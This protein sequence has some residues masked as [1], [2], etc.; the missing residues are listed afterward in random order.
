MS[1]Y[2]IV[3]FWLLFV[4]V[5]YAESLFLYVS[6]DGNDQWSGR[7]ANASEQDGPFATIERA[8]Q[9]VRRL[10]SVDSL[11]G[12]MTVYLRGGVYYLKQEIL[13]TPED[14]GREDAPIRYTNYDDETVFI[15]GGRKLTAWRHV[16]DN[17]WVCDLPEAKGDSWRFQQLFVNGERRYRART[18]N[19]G[20]L[21]V[22]DAMEKPGT[23]FHEDRFKFGFFPGDLLSNWRN[24][25]DI[26]IVLLTFWSDAHCPIKKIDPESLVVTLS[27]PSWRK[28]TDDNSDLGARYFVDNVYEGMD[29]PGEWYLDR[30]K[31]RLYYLAMP[32][33][34]MT[35]AEVIAP[36]LDQLIRFNGD[37]MAQQY[38][39]N[40]AISGLHFA[41]T[42]WRL[43]PGDAGDHQAADS[44]PGAVEMVG[45]RHVKIENC[46]FEHLGTYGMEILD[47]CRDIVIRKNYIH[48]LGGGGVK[49]SGG[50]A[51]SDSLL[52]T[53]HITFSDN[54]LK[55]MGRLYKASVGVLL[56]HASDNII[57]HNLIKDLFYT[58][59]S[60]GWEW[61][62]QA[63]AAY[64]NLIEFNRVENVG[65]GMLS[66]MGG[67]YLLGVSPGTVVRNNLVTNVYSHGY[68][69]WGIYT[70]EGSS[71]ILIEKNIVY[72]TKSAGF[73]QHYGQNNTIRNNIFAFGHIAQ[74][75]RS[76][77]E[78][79]LSF[80]FDRNIVYWQDSELLGKKWDGDTT[81]FYFQN[82]IYFR[83]DE[84]PIEFL[85]YSVEKWVAR[86]QDASS[87]FADPKFVDP[88][89][90][91]FNL[92]PDSPAF[93]V[94]F[95]PI[96]MT[97][98]G[99]RL[100]P[101][102]V[103]DISYLS[104]ADSTMQPA[105]FYDSGS[106]KKKPLLVGLH[107]W[108]GNY[109]QQGS[110]PWFRWC[111]LKDWAFI[112]PN[113]RGPND[114][115]EA[116][117][118]DLVIG[119]ILS[120]V[121]YAREHANIDTTRIFLIGVSGGG[122]TT[123]QTVAKAPDVWAAASAWASI[124]DLRAWHEESLERGRRY[125]AMI[126][127]SCGGAPGVA[128]SID[129]EYF[130]RSPIN[131]LANAQAVPLDINAGIHDGHS[132]SVP[133]SHSLRA[134]NAVAADS[135]RIAEEAIWRMVR[136]EAVP[137]EL[138]TNESDPYYGDKRVLLRRQS[139]NARITIFDGGHEIIPNAALHWLQQQVK[140]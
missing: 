47:G 24:I 3:V 103:Q 91:D 42:D 129:A 100:W 78:E 75:M 58:G 54:S 127:A 80:T 124:S 122:Y 60:V 46:R 73:H 29:Q 59:I 68:G 6:P 20:Y 120:A 107:T 82:N 53:S 131:F 99:P 114:H 17:R 77:D 121:K 39:E 102:D 34:D 22:K 106:A 71:D 45:T 126:E 109:Q 90:G 123:L 130:K 50:R 11:R 35:T 69:G 132:G 16:R 19:D 97:A 74:L 137:Q 87:M 110:L 12:P 14:S 62:Y 92:L 65:E 27:T 95:E 9:E 49:I 135:H 51:G 119:D 5:S 86:G 83:V 108:S 64:N 105:L 112:H 79:H 63:S 18:P 136:D 52:K 139:N 8:Q 66:D 44:V 36:D 31:G 33:E 115:P 140:K 96:D 98:I 81:R 2:R 89:H 125:A 67:I 40:I 38:V 113:F 1:F 104:A 93:G 25:N 72:D 28:F 32:N 43:P 13:F 118:S 37:P 76:R 41:H 10:K 128:D 61:G 70:D 138:L 23:P 88:E 117:G 56:R 94:G 15:S 134:F 116:T 111:R 48:D 26:E 7:A 101:D 4:C 30:T 21:R 57:S 85:N 84:K 55:E 133:V